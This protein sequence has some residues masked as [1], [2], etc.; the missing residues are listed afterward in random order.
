VTEL[1]AGVI[2]GSGSAWFE[3]I[4]HTAELLPIMVIPSWVSTRIQPIAIRDVLRALVD[5]LAI[6]AAR[7]EVLEL[8][9]PEVMTFREMMLR[10]AR[11][12]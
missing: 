5:V 3:M 12:A 7:G 9:G 11:A 4:R 2:I 10:Y 6:D 1:R 8:G